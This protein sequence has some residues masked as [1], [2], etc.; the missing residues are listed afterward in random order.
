MLQVCSSDTAERCDGFGSAT[1]DCTTKR[2]L[3]RKLMPYIEAPLEGV[4]LH[5]VHIVHLGT[6]ATKTVD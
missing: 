2:F 5:S 6:L 3:E 1:G 4:L